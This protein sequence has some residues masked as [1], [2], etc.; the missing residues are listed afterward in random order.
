M[1][2]T[3]IKI[4]LGLCYILVINSFSYG[5]Q[6]LEEDPKM[7]LAE[8][9]FNNQNYGSALENYLNLEGRVFNAPYLKYKIGLCYF[10]SPNQKEKAIEYLKYALTYRNEK[11]P[12]EVYYY[13]GRIYHYTYKFDDAIEMFKSYK[14][15]ERNFNLV[16][17]DT[18]RLIE[19]CYNGKNILTMDDKDIEVKIASPPTNTS[20]D[21]YAPLVRPNGQLLMFSSDRP[22]ESVDLVV[23]PKHVFIPEHLRNNNE[24]VF[25]AYPRGISWDFP[26]P[27]GLKGKKI[28]P[29]SFRAQGSELLLFIGESLTQGDLYISKY[30]GSRWTPPKKLDSSINSRYE[31]RG[32]CFG[33]D[34]KVIYFSSNRPNGYG[35]FDL[36]VSKQDGKTWGSPINLGPNI[37]SKY[38]EVTPFM[39]PDEQTFY[40]SSDGH[41]SMGGLDIFQSNRIK[42]YTSWEMPINLGFPINSTYDDD[43]F[44]QRTDGKYSFLSSNRNEIQSVG[45]TDIVSIF[46]PEKK[47]PMAM[48]KGKLTVEKD[49]EL[50]DVKLRVYDKHT[51]EQ[52]RYVYNPDPETGEYFMILTPRKTY[53][54]HIL[55]GE[56]YKHIIDIT[57][58]EQA[59]S[60][61]L[62]KHI[63][64]EPYEVFGQ[65]IGE[66]PNVQS[67]EYILT[68]V[69]DV[70]KGRSVKYDALLMIMERIVD[71][72]DLQQ[73]NSYLNQLENPTP[74]PTKKGQDP[75]Y[76][77]LLTQIDNILEREDIQALRNLDKPVLK[78]DVVFS[79]TIENNRKLVMTHAVLFDA[80]DALINEETQTE[81]NKLGELLKQDNE[82]QLEISYP[83]NGEQLTGERV[84]AI[85]NFFNIRSV[86]NHQLKKRKD[87]SESVN[88]IMIYLY[89]ESQ[90]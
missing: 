53:E 39:H 30:R 48:V 33:E 80:E 76:D 22:T 49:N 86:L 29:L 88:N 71:A 34:G 21:D 75:Y 73:G 4:L 1:S 23:D 87:S 57:L 70:P 69:D 38:D 82:L 54:M 51:N 77:K 14:L 81:L 26:Y 42:G 43:H 66:K 3:T 17:I 19:M 72:Q 56:N 35:G 24:E 79:G 55:T 61:E 27:Q 10:H 40:F 5:Q 63:I 7:I 16:F 59:Y 11:V 52:Q 2:K 6:S 78:K 89:E 58:P 60:Y 18:D 90:L 15:D 65:Q 64:I 32:A 74:F 36:Y 84:N 44:V 8:N 28:V 83:N 45:A 62:N 67:S 13:L 20:F 25:A 47:N 31:E 85:Y 12:P 37:N 41:N 50:V 9:L 46:K 68:K